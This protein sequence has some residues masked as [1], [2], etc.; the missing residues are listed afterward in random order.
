MSDAAAGWLQVGLL[1]AAL[2]AVHRPLGDWMARVFTGERHW[3]GERL[4]YRAAGVDADSEQR[5][6][7]YLR[8]VLAFSVVGVL[9]RAPQSP[10]GH[11]AAG[12]TS[13]A[14][15]PARHLRTLGADWGGRGDADKGSGALTDDQ[16]RPRAANLRICRPPGPTPASLAGSSPVTHPTGEGPGQSADQGLHTFPGPASS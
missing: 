3:R 2:A 6:P 14:P 15:A 9:R 12:R 13:A 11:G 16:G 1:I 10:P 5:W 7:V 4:V 8:S